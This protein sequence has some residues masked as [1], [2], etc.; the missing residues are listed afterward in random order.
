MTSVTLTITGMTCSHCV[1]K[2][3]EALKGAQGVYG[4]S[5]DLEHGGAEVDYDAGRA[6]LEDLMAGVEIAGYQAARAG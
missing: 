5:V 4:A 6:T 2:V 1:T 3:E